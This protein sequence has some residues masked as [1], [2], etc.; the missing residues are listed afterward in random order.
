MLIVNPC[1]CMV[2]MF[3]GMLNLMILLWKEHGIMF[4]FGK[5]FSVNEATA[6]EIQIFTGICSIDDSMNSKRRSFLSKLPNTGNDVVKYLH[7]LAIHQLLFWD[8]VFYICV[9]IRELV[10]VFICF[11]TGTW[12]LTI[13]P[14]ITIVSISI[15]SISIVILFSFIDIVYFL[16]CCPCWRNKLH[17]ILA[18][19]LFISIHLRKQRLLEL[20]FQNSQILVW[21]PYVFISRFNLHPRR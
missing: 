19:K 5:I 7:D 4:F 6:C 12:Y 3:T 15:I 2:Q 10:S 13:P 18:Y 21:S 17:N 14:I 8:L 20:L 9:L 1:C 11:I 16:C